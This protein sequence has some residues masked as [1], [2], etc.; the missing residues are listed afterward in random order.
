MI[1]VKLNRIYQKVDQM[2]KLLLYCYFSLIFIT[3]NGF[4]QLTEKNKINFEKG[5]IPSCIETQSRHEKNKRF[6]ANELRDY[7]LCNSEHIAERAL[8]ADINKQ[9]E[10]LKKIMDDASILCTGRYFLKK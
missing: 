3:G 1:I 5:F 6:S 10:K 7:C 4:A 9:T 2:K 8:V